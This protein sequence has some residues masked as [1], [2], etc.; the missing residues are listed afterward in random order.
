[1]GIKNL[2]KMPYLKIAGVSNLVTKDNLREL[3]QCCGKIENL[4]LIRNNEKYIYLIEFK[5]ESEAETAQMISNT[6]LGDSKLIVERITNDEGKKLLSKI[7]IRKR[8]PKNEYEEALNKMK[9]MMQGPIKNEGTVADEVQRTIYIGN[10]HN[11]V[12]GEQLR[13]LFETVGDTLYVKFSGTSQFR[14]AFVE[15]ATK[16]A[17]K[18]AFALHGTFLGGQSIKVGQAHNPI[19]KDDASTNSDANL[20]AAKK[21]IEKLTLKKQDRISLPRIEK[22]HSHDRNQRRRKRNKSKN[23]HE[24]KK[25]RSNDRK[26]SRSSVENKNDQG[27]VFWDG[28]QWH[29]NMNTITNSRIRNSKNIAV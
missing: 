29:T 27:G 24:K 16:E 15:Y 23:K 1:M 3:F 5:N 18:A 26:R 12:K 13:A 28:F 11:A 14:Y 25:R 19:F 10:L 2:K 17:A 21:Q 9:E 8:I 6:E 20:R 4:I 7:S 22:R